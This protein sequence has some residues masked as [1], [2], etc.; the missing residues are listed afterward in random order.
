[1][2]DTFTGS[3]ASA[4]RK[5]QLPAAAR[6]QAHV[7]VVSSQV[8][9]PPD[10]QEQI[11]ATQGLV[12]QTDS[13]SAGPDAAHNMKSFNEAGAAVAV[14]AEM[15]KNN[16]EQIAALVNSRERDVNELQTTLA[17]PL[18]SFNAKFIWHCIMNI[19]HDCE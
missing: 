6:S 18:A 1:M 17:V 15:Q 7:P 19:E 16:Q 11:E 8:Y 14:P 12:F 9:G 13:Q 10:L 5:L 4:D 3:D 2:E